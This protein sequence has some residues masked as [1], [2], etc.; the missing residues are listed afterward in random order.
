MQG[1]RAFLADAL[2]DLAC[3]LS[4]AVRSYRAAGYPRTTGAGGIAGGGGGGGDG[5]T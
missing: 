1:A 3:A 5:A 4:T 2:C